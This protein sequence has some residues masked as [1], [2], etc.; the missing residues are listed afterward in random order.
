MNILHVAVIPAMTATVAPAFAEET[1]SGPA[2]VIDGDTLEIAGART[3]LWGVKAGDPAWGIGWQA[4]LFLSM[5][6]AEGPVS[7]TLNLRDPPLWQCLTVHGSD[8][9][10]LLVQT[11]L[12]Y[13]A[14]PYY[15]LEETGARIAERGLWRLDEGSGR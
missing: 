11:G 14:G 8:L 10:S 13:A 9:G 2:V 6:V 4:K 15:Q 5:V 3:A 1:R 7:C 12:A